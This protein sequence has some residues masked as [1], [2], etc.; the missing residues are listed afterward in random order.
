MPVCIGPMLADR[1]ASYIRAMSYL[2]LSVGH[3]HLH[4]KSIEGDVG[5]VSVH[6]VA[7]HFNLLHFSEWTSRELEQDA[8]HPIVGQSPLHLQAS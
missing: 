8:R 5:E 7:C 6:Q 4:A 3:P 2:A 1:F